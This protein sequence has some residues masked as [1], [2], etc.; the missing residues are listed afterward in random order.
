MKEYRYL[1]SYEYAQK[2]FC[3]ELNQE[4][5][6]NGYGDVLAVI[7][8]EPTYKVIDEIRQEMKKKNNFSAMVILNIIRLEKVQ[9]R[10]LNNDKRRIK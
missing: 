6:S 5:T 2:E 9:K 7:K 10:K 3:E 1:I 4:I 8:G